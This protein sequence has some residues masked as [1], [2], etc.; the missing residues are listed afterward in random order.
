MVIRAWALQLD[1]LDSDHSSVSGIFG[2]F[3]NFS[4]LG[5]FTYNIG[6]LMSP[7]S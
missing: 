4:V 5:F 3:P 1:C 2:N 7:S 6:M